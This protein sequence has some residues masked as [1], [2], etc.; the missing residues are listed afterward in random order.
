MGP[1]EKIQEQVTIND[2]IRETEGL[3]SVVES[4]LKRDIPVNEPVCTSVGSEDKQSDF[5][6]E[7]YS[8][9]LKKINLRLSLLNLNLRNL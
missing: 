1:E 7:N 5:K 8:N 4:N 9:R 6:I 2:L 3:L